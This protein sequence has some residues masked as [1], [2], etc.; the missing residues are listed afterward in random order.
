MW[1]NI[2]RVMQCELLRLP[3][4]FYISLEE[5]KKICQYKSLTMQPDTL[6][7]SY[8]LYLRDHNKR[9]LFLSLLDLFSFIKSLYK[10][11]SSKEAFEW[12][13]NSF[14]ELYAFNRIYSYEYHITYHPV[15]LEWPNPTQTVPLTSHA[16]TEDQGNSY[17]C[18]KHFCRLEDNP[19]L[20]LKEAP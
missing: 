17:L 2:N 12:T 8:R 20:F 1:K 14:E 7:P 6:L 10:S 5:H 16:G 4:D 19:N 13:V 3:N 11:I 9:N 15:I 18:D